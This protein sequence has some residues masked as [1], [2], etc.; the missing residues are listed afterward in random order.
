MIACST[1]PHA[2]P[3]TLQ[4]RRTDNF[5]PRCQTS[6]EAIIRSSLIMITFLLYPLWPNRLPAAE[7]I[8]GL[9]LGWLADSRNEI[10]VSGRLNKQTLQDQAKSLFSDSIS[11]TA[12]QLLLSHVMIHRLLNYS[13]GPNA[14]SSPAILHRS[15]RCRKGKQE[16]PRYAMIRV[17]PR[18]VRNRQKDV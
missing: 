10:A 6:L 3:H 4:S 9:G 14:P 15:C 11:T 17:R 18:H 7:M 13:S 5:P 16:T 8:W 2:H 1:H 12:T